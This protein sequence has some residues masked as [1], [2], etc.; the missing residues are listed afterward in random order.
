MYRKPVSP[1]K[2][3][4]PN[5]CLLDLWL[6]VITAPLEQNGI[7]ADMCVEQ[8]DWTVG[9]EWFIVYRTVMLSLHDESSCD[10]CSSKPLWWLCYVLRERSVSMEDIWFCCPFM[11]RMQRQCA[12]RLCVYRIDTVT[13]GSCAE[14]MR[15]NK[16]LKLDSLN[17]SFL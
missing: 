2:G 9:V 13:E 1:I 7:F 15:F 8:T 17:L 11:F 5:I 16:S 12:Q 6:Y 3:L 10:Q 4:A 14:L